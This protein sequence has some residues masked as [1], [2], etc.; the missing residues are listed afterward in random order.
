[1]EIKLNGVVIHFDTRT[2]EEWAAE[3]RVIPDG[4]LCVEKADGDKTK[5]KV[6]DGKRTY[7]QLPYAGTE[8]DLDD[9]YNKKAIDDKLA[10]KIGKNDTLVLH[11]SLPETE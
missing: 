4:F 7:E 3:K 8:V 5:L 1:M 6:G 10:E 9:Y 11:C 2:T